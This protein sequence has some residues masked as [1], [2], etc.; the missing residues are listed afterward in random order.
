MQI[1]NLAPHVLPKFCNALISQY[2]ERFDFGSGESLI[3]IVH[4]FT[5]WASVVWF[6]IHNPLLRRPGWMKV[7]AYTFEDT[8]NIFQP[9][10]LK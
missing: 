7:I 3:S 5:G 6:S 8:M 4:E 2:R 10:R 1:I 9:K